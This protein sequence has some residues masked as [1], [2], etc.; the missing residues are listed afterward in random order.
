[1]AAAN[2]ALERK[3]ALL[4]PLR[5]RLGVD[6]E[7]VQARLVLMHLRELPVASVALDELALALD[8]LGERLD[9]LARTGIALLALRMVQIPAQLQVH[10]KIC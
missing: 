1:M 5:S 4:A 2:D 7:R 6:L 8:R 10:P 3:H 9:V